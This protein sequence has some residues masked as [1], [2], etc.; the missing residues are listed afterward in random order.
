MATVRRSPAPD[1]KA[2]GRWGDPDFVRA[3]FEPFAENIR[4]EHRA[5]RLEAESAEDLENFFERFNGPQIATRN[6][7]PEPRY[8]E[9][10]RELIGLT[11]EFNQADDGSVLIDSAWLLVV[12]RKVRP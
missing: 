9:L 3:R 10:H 12:A 11:E 1:P 8:A 2:P 7:L 5:A 6:M 4:F